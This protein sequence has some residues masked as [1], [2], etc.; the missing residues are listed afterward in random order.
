M[1]LLPVDFDAR[2]PSKTL[3]ALR[4]R[5]FLSPDAFDP[6]VAFVA[7]DPSFFLNLL[8]AAS[9][10]AAAATAAAGLGIWSLHR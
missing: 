1:N 9:A 10:V 4:C 2:A 6:L 7:F 5:G 8:P 3:S